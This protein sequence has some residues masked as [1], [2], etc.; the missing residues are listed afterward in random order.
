MSSFTCSIN[1]TISANLQALVYGSTFFLAV[2]AVYDQ[3]WLKD[4]SSFW[5][6]WPNQQFPYATFY[7]DAL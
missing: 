5:R 4:T 6:D 1:D 2:Y 3:P 7:L